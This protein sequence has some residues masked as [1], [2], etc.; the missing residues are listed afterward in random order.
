MTNL[1]FTPLVPWPA[2]VA[3]A[4][5]A[6][7]LVG[8]AAR[9]RAA[10]TV[11]RAL[12][13]A[14]MVSALANPTLVTERREALS[15]VVAVVVDRS[16]SQ[17]IGQRT[18]RTDAAVTALRDRLA[19]H[20]E[21]E[22]RVV[23]AGSGT[24]G[25]GGAPEGTDL[26]GALDRMLSDVPAGRIAGAIVITD[27]QVHDAPPAGA[28]LTRLADG[29]P[30]HALLTGE[31]DEAD[32]RLVV[33]EAPTYGIVDS[34]LDIT[35]RVED[36]GVVD[37]PANTRITLRRDGGEPEAHDVPVGRNVR[38]PLMLDHGGPTVV[39]IDVAAGPRELI[40]Q[41]NRAA[42]TVNGVRERLRVLLVSGEPH[43]GERTWRNLLKA[44]PAVDLVH[45]TILRPPEKQD[46]TPVNE[47]SLIAFPIRELFETKLA[48]F[49]LIIFDQYRRRGVLPTAYFLNI[50]RYVS[51]GGALLGAVGPDFASSLSI[52]D[53]PLK[54]IFPGAPTGT[55]L[56][57][58]FRPALTTTGRRHP[59][60]AD[61]PGSGAGNAT[62][63][64]AA[65]P[66]WGR[67]FRMIE[68]AP[69]RGTTV[70]EGT[71]GRPLL[72]LDRVGDG[73]V[74]LLS[75]D[76][77]WLWARGAEGGGP[78]AELLRRLAHWLM[79]EPDLEEEDLRAVAVGER[80]D[81]TRRSLAPEPPS[82]T[83]TAP[84]GETQALTLVHS[85]GGRW[86]GGVPVRETGLYSVSDG[87]RTAVTV[88]GS[89]NAQEF[90]DVR[91]TDSVMAPS[92]AATGGATFWL[93]DG[94]PNLRP[95]RPGR[96][97]AGRDWLGL[98]ANRSFL[99]TG[100]ER[101][102]LLPVAVLLALLLGTL[103]LAWYREGR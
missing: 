76:H 88:V 24:G 17:H 91:A 97:T 33:V 14:A 87:T 58:G 20:P 62:G 61:L 50:V 81:V 71:G 42:L 101:L 30:L 45:F 25:D 72:T 21:F 7:L 10:G 34:P 103:G 98:T 35:L 90:A 37:G 94:M 99:V 47:L 79:K 9:R 75:S 83:V 48:D 68:I 22:V 13:F 41:N 52:Y 8:A 67:W 11:W 38:L 70:L 65:D 27:G 2:I 16:A 36:A 5:V 6:A 29:R 77:A 66:T 89:L 73:R 46:G 69:D 96:D 32:R 56:E 15:D 100:V 12:A 53:T 4:T 39:E 63:D 80:I 64:T 19:R 82:V 44:D 102:P 93:A 74:A 92:V 86:T 51:E 59:V 31:K 43:A 60:T 84:S 55:V 78:Q 28:P 54:V 23:E 3:V 40:L 57:G 95:V 1:E 85:G 49:D 18:E 26:F